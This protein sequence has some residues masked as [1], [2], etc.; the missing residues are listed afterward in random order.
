[1]KRIKTIKTTVLLTLLLALFGSVE[2]AQAKP[3]KMYGKHAPFTIRDL[4]SQNGFRRQLEG[5]HPLHQQKAIKRLHSFSFP[6]ADL[7][8]L[9]VDPTG[10][11]LYSDS[12]ILPT[13]STLTT[14]GTS[15]LATSLPVVDTFA[16]HSRPNSKNV[17]YLDFN[18]DNITGSAW[19]STVNTYYAAPF[20][21]DGIPTDFN[22]DERTR[23][24]EIWHRIA[25]DFSAFDIDVT[26]E[27]PASFGPTTG[28][29]LFTKNVDT[30]GVAMPYKSAGGV[31]YVNVFGDTNYASYY[32]PALIYYNNLGGGSA[33]Y[34]AEAGAHEFGH[35][36]G[37]SH[38]GITD[39]TLNPKCSTT[40]EYF[41]G[42]DTS[43]SSWAPIMGVGYYTNVTQWS[44]GEYA[45]AN[46]PE[47][48]ILLITEKLKLRADDQQN[49][50][51]NATALAI[52]SNGSV[53]VTTPQDDPSNA[54]PANKGVIESRDDV[55][56]FWFE[57]SSG[58]I[59]VTVKPAWAAFTRTSKRGANLD[60][61]AKLYNQQGVEIASSAPDTETSAV[62]S[63]TVT[64][65]IYY[66]SIAGVGNSLVPYSDYASS[67]E[68]FI[69]GTI[70]VLDKTAPNPDP[71]G[72]ASAPTA[73][74]K[75]SIA[76]VATT[77]TDASGTVQYQFQ[78]VAGGLGCVSSAWQT[79][80]SYTATGLATSTNYSF[81]VTAKD[82]SGNMT[83]P[84]TI[85]STSTLANQAPLA[86]GESLTANED[87]WIAVYALKNDT[88]PD[89]D[90]LSI[91]AVGTPAHGVIVNN[92]TS[93]TYKPALNYNGSDSFSYTVSDGAGGTAS[94]TVN[95]TL[96]PVNDAPQTINDKATVL[97]NSTATIDVLAN[98][99]D[100]E[101]NPLTLV[102]TSS[103]SLGS[104][105]ITNNKIVYTAGS[106]VGIDIFSYTVSDGNGGSKTATITVTIK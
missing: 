30:K 93:M 89:G 21:I 50:F 12:V 37:L 76:M 59:N 23:I 106:L 47:D 56:M 67:G 88:D 86:S 38:D 34:A 80:S 81:T 100:V 28:H 31:A 61:Q 96:L 24:A 5:L 4:P 32:S 10:E 103:P 101:F 64:P 39:K 17:L 87:K 2:Q 77:A 58:T 84:S 42:L 11:V 52:E 7:D 9:N 15:T 26:T 46:N 97:V 98:D 66:L 35:N 49:G 90:V 91:S 54:D 85:T 18:G 44:K 82:S 104:A 41:C 33:P 8:H 6:E 65:G 3:A 57:A 19:N 92:G 20:D 22:S 78:C 51:A 62:I 69:S 105:V 13:Q 14:S 27:E 45:G 71:M 94:A 25:E 95:I 102:S 99:K 74:S 60:V 83:A 55:D 70:P 53:L 16:F 75:S 68:Y 79:S 36:L 63:T 43:L 29:L 48:D 1:M 72:W 40:A 73:K